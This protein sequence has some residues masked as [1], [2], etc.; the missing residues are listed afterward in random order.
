LVV[1]TLISA[2][3]LIGLNA[4]GHQSVDMADTKT[5]D[6]E[7]TSAP[8]PPVASASPISTP[9]LSAT[10]DFAGIQAI[11][12]QGDG[13]ENDARAQNTIDRNPKTVWK[14]SYYAT[15]AFAGLKQG[16]GLALRMADS[17]PVQ[18]IKIDIQGSGGVVELRTAEGPGLDGSTVVATS[19]IKNGHA[20]LTPT[21][22]VNSRWLILWFTTLPK[23]SH[24]YQLVIS[25]ISVL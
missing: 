21:S 5:T 17:T 8:T 14:S 1:A 22:A 13:S 4:R 24:Q 11:D 23:V 9:T 12:P 6:A 25:E 19:S 7:A 20:V 3:A 18:Q 2:V 16:V 10:P 15:A